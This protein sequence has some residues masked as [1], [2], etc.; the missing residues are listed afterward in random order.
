MLY[1]FLVD[2]GSMLT[3]DMN[4]AMGTVA[5]LK[6]AIYDKTGIT[7]DKQVLLINGGEGLSNKNRVCDYSSAGKTETWPFD[8]F[9]DEPIVFDFPGTDT[10]PIFLFSKTAIEMSAPPTPTIDYYGSNSSLISSS[11]VDLKERIDSCLNMDASYQTVIARTEL[12]K[13][14]C[15]ISSQIVRDCEKLV[16]DQHLQHQ[17]W[18]AV[19][20]NLEDVVSIFKSSWNTLEGHISQ[21]FQEKSLSESFLESFHEDLSLLTRIPMLRELTQLSP[22]ASSNNES[23]NEEAST[24]FDWINSK[25]HQRNLSEVHDLCMQGLNRFDPGFLDDLKNE[26]QKA[27][28]MANNNDMKEIKSM[29]DRLFGLEQL[30]TQARKLA[31][32][33][34]DYSNAFFKNQ[35]RVRE[36]INARENSI[37]PDLCKSHRMQLEVMNKNHAQLKDIKKRC[38]NSKVDIC[39]NINHRL[40]WI[41]YTEKKMTEIDEKILVHRENIRRLKLHMEI[42]RQIHLAP[43]LYV[44]AVQEVVRRRIFSKVFSDWTIMISKDSG[45]VFKEETK[46]RQSF[47]ALLNNH[48]L[49]TMFPGIS[50]QLPSFALEAPAAFDNGL[51]LLEIDHVNM[52]RK[53]VPELFEGLGN[54][55]NFE[56]EKVLKK[57]FKNEKG[58]G[59]NSAQESNQVKIIND[60]VIDV[61]GRHFVRVSVLMKI[62]AKTSTD[63][64]LMRQQLN[65]MKETCLSAVNEVTSEVPKI[66]SEVQEKFKE[67]VQT[68]NRNHDKQIKDIEHCHKEE[69]LKLKDTIARITE[70]KN[71]IQGELNQKETIFESEK[72]AWDS[73]TQDLQQ[74]INQIKMEILDRELDL[75]ES[76]KREEDQ[77]EVLQELKTRM[78]SLVDSMNKKDQEL[79]DSTEAL[80]Q[81]NHLL[82]KEIDKLKQEAHNQTNKIEKEL[83]KDFEAERSAA[84]KL[85]REQL[86]SEH[87]REMETLRSRFRLASSIEKA[88]DSLSL[89][90][91]NFGC[92]TLA[93]EN[94]FLAEQIRDLKKEHLEFIERLQKDHRDQ[95][96]KQISEAVK[97]IESKMAKEKDALVSKL[98]SEIEVLK[99]QVADKSAVASSTSAASPDKR[100]STPTLDSPVY[101]SLDPAAK[102]VRL[103]SMIRE[104]DNRISKLQD[105]FRVNISFLQDR[106]S[107]LS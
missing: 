46:M 64:V 79:K 71:V 51:P 13:Q 42:I 105:S 73:A 81:E 102:V 10:S 44:A 53:A 65:V 86:K 58:N 76:K 1:V 55:V 43:R 28:N 56:H 5:A 19:V 66:V 61:N 95:L 90:S 45:F 83:R 35:Q 33:Q 38:I 11:E 2:T 96:D 22:M 6:E 106:I 57:Y 12:A 37:I 41:M 75:E 82:K 52:L 34:T 15:D 26:A 36:T 9:N 47:I 21:F 54:I 23:F 77:D 4:L 49:S 100:C 40:K 17:G 3:L 7:E 27:L 29:G 107:F 101:Q 69:V 50:D 63:S 8:Q 72:Q 97:N 24:L 18:Q 16:H 74:Q 99:K 32:E 25:D 98:K 85:Q 94:E 87:K 67:A 59:E 84:L 78:T 20:A 92:E 39:G 68:V 30:L 48:F 103:E 80:V 104:K 31:A 88:Q 91:P 89:E 93:T 14:I 70:E 60:Y 62:F